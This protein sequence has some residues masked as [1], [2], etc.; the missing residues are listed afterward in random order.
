[1]VAT[2]DS[3]FPQYFVLVH[4]VLAPGLCEMKFYGSDLCQSQKFLCVSPKPLLNPPAVAQDETARGDLQPLHLLSLL[5]RG[6]S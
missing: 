2:R 1:M 6:C 4:L 5:P 3:Y